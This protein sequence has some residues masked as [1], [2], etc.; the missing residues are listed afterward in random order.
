MI[1]V[2]RILSF[3]FSTEPFYRSNQ[4]HFAVLWNNHCHSYSK[5][6]YKI[7]NVSKVWYIFLKNKLYDNSKNYF[8][9]ILGLAPLPADHHIF[10]KKHPRK[11][12]QNV[13]HYFSIL[14]G[15]YFLPF[16]KRY[17]CQVGLDI[18]QKF[19]KN[20]FWNCY[21]ICSSKICITPLSYL[22]F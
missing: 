7:K 11:K 13:D 12:C 10:W 4:F 9:K 2:Q 20:N 1:F 15:V 5:W 18:M 22:F 17:R 14:E 6:E 19:S 21:I 8:S 3:P 16:F